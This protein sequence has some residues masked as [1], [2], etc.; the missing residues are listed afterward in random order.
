MDPGRFQVRPEAAA[1]LHCFLVSDILPL[2]WTI[3]SGPWTCTALRVMS[4]SHCW[5]SASCRSGL[6]LGHGPPI[7][8]GQPTKVGNSDASR[9]AVGKTATLGQVQV[10]RGGSSL[11]VGVSQTLTDAQHSSKS[12]SSHP[13][14]RDLVNV[15]NIPHVALRPGTHSPVFGHPHV[16][17]THIVSCPVSVLAQGKMFDFLCV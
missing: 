13:A 16:L 1:L 9:G 4:S 8:T 11:P 14:A 6:H 17:G 10:S 3:R 5:W 7:L 15:H 12:R 2:A